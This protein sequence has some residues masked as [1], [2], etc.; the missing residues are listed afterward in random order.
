M[1]T[2]KCQADADTGAVSSSAQAPLQSGVCE[3]G[4]H[5][6]VGKRAVA[7]ADWYWECTFCGMKRT[8]NGEVMQPTQ[9]SLEEAGTADDASQQLRS[10]PDTEEDNLLACAM[11]RAQYLRARNEVK[12]PDIL[13][14]LVSR[15]VEAENSSEVLRSQLNEAVEII[16]PFAAIE[17]SSFFSADG[18]E[19][20]GYTVSLSG[21]ARTDFTGH[22]LARA[23]AFLSKIESGRAIA[24]GNSNG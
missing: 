17:P 5:V 11:G 18:S 2:D 15:S 9:R 19:A 10:Q 16:R 6:W 14:A 3:P 13:E 21:E 20:E 4:D 7:T 1:T 8:Q 22:D 12:T 23:R 24:E